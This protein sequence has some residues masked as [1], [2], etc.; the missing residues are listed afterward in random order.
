MGAGA[1]DG[2]R[3]R[4]WRG[5]PAGARA[6]C[7]AHG[8][9]AELAVFF[10]PA[11]APCVVVVA[12]LMLMLSSVGFTVEN[13]VIILEALVWELVNALLDGNVGFLC[14]PSCLL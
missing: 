1:P 10:A 4:L 13:A 11:L 14:L 8:L 7:A 3:T 9:R 12:V 5:N 6:N 2:P